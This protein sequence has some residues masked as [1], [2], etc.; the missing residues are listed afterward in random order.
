[1]VERLERHEELRVEEAGRVAAVVG[2]A[3]LRHDG[4]DFGVTQQDGA[5]LVDRRHAGFERNRRRHGRADPQVPLF[6][7]R[8]ELAA[9]PRGDKAGYR[10]KDEPDRHRDLPI[11][12]RALQEGRVDAADGANDHRLDL[13]HPFG[14]QQ[15]RQA[16]RHRERRDQRPHQR[17]GVSAGHRAEDLPLHPRHG[18]QG[19]ERRHDDRGGEEHGAIDLQRAHHDQ[20]QPVVPAALLHGGVGPPG[21][22][23][24]LMQQALPLFRRGLEV[25]IDVFHQ[26][27]RGIDDDAEIDR[28]DR[29]QVGVLVAQHQDDHAEEQRERDVGADDDRAAQVAEKSPL[30]QENEQAAEHEVVQHGRRRHGDQ[31]A[32]VVDRNELHAGRKRPV[33]VDLLDLAAHTC[34]HVVGVQRA[35]HDHDRRDHVVLVVAPRLAE[36]R[37]DSDRDFGDLL[38]E[39]RHAVRLE[40]QDVFDVLDLVALGEVRGAAA[41]DEA[42]AAYVDRLLAEV[43]RAPADVD[44]GV[45]DRADDLRQGDVVGVEFVKIDFDVV[46]LGGSAPGVHLHHARHGEEAALEHPIL[47]GAQ[48]G[49][50]EVRRPGELIA[51]DFPDQAR[52]LNLRGD[53]VGQV[54]VLLQIDRGLGE[55]EVIIDA[56]L[57]HD[58]H[59]GEAVERSRADD[60]HPRRGGEADLERDRVVTLHLLRR[61]AGGLRGDLQDD[62]GRVR[63]GL[64]IE[65]REG[66]HARADEHQQPEQHERPARQREC[67]KPLE[68][69]SSLPRFALTRRRFSLA[70]PASASHCES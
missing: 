51:I 9:E 3:V 61:Q 44:V 69:R 24:Q 20:P 45:A 15:R 64:D 52:P 7:R 36:P 50:A 25:A 58:A 53:V 37:H 1:M 8:Q 46:F 19:N 49:Q 4:D 38:D 6:Q 65:A 11:P 30:D 23:G 48:I 18:E 62:G 2:A 70:P 43:D 35:V 13:A 59:E 12:E 27:H 56:V 40:Q 66:E 10:K 67:D 39:H 57:E 34:G 21:L 63:V 54:D 22:F 26:D 31:G 55:R 17:V 47:H 16:G 5:D 41:V 29:Q 42:D 60:V 33:A 32:A 68:H 14:H 28:A